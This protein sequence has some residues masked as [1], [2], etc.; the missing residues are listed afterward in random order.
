MV[1]LEGEGLGEG[2]FPVEQRLS[3]DG[4]DEVEVDLERAG[5]AEEVDGLDGLHG[6]VLAA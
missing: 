4:E 6:G 2:V 5:F 1:G 3:G